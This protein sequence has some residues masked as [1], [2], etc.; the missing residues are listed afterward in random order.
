MGGAYI[1][2][3]LERLDGGED[4]DEDAED[5]DDGSEEAEAPADDQQGVRPQPDPDG[6][7]VRR[8]PGGLACLRVSR[9][10]RRG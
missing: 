5:G 6:R 9:H 3:V 1:G 10:R 2:S 7:D 8:P 4:V